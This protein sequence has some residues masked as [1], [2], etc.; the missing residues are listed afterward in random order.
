M[1]I[2][3]H[4][5]TIELDQFLAESRA[6]VETARNDDVVVR[7]LGGFAIFIHSDH[8][9]EGRNLQINAGRLGEGKPAFTDLDLIGYSKQYG[10]IRD[11]LEKKL[12]LKP[13]RMINALYG[14]SRL[15]YYHPAADFPIDVFFDKL[16]FSHE[17]SF[18]EKNNGRLEF[19]YP[20]LDLADLMLEKL[21]VHDINRKDLIDVAVLI[22]GHDFSENESKD[23]VN[24]R[25]ISKTLAN[26]WGFWYDATQNLEHVKSFCKQL[27]EEGRLTN[28]SWSTVESRIAYLKN[29]IQEEP[30]TEAWKVRSRVS[31]LKPWYRV[32]EDL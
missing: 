10:K 27:I 17:V 19:D 18:G 24:A 1:S 15:V 14:D 8:C 23:S 13:D 5:V 16:D 9:N 6:I 20:T 30:K 25:Y 32:V 7:I 28:S 12:H 29:I 11:V 22:L 31:V 3:R 26:D 2:K 4:P 21:Q